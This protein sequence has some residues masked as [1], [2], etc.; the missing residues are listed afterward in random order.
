M[1][2]E[3]Y[4]ALLGNMSNW[5]GFEHFLEPIKHFKDTIFEKI[6]K[7]YQPSSGP[8]AFNVLNHGDFHFKNMLY[9]MDNEGGKIEDFMAAS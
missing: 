8:G 5:E 2:S 6:L 4:D 7:T 9:K 3:G 1:F